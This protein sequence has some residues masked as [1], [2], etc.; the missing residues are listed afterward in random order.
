[1][2]PHV[3]IICAVHVLCANCILL[4][5]T[6]P[7]NNDTDVGNAQP[8]APSLSQADNEVSQITTKA[9]EKSID[10]AAMGSNTQVSK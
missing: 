1:M 7:T 2:A 3:L 5:Q 8:E 10:F 4:C 9:D 6:A